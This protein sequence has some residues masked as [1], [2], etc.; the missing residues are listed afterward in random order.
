MA[1]SLHRHADNVGDSGGVSM[2][3][4]E[5]DGEIKTE[6][7]ARPRVGVCI[8]VGSSYARTMQWQDWWQTSYITKILTDEEDKVVFETRNSIYTWT[9]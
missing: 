5:E 8:Q 1:Y 3:I 6:H 7:N 4:W 2:A 9:T